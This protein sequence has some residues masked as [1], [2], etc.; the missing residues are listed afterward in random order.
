MSKTEP[1][2]AEDRYGAASDEC[3]NDLMPK[4]ISDL[5][6]IRGFVIL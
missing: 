1:T 3:P 6:G 4:G 5:F 2:F